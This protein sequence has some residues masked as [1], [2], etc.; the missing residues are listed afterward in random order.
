MAAVCCLPHCTAAIGDRTAMIVLLVLLTARLQ[1]GRS[2]AELTGY[3]YT[4]VRTL[5]THAPRHPPLRD[6]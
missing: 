6:A 2:C 1:L 4:T 5:L 3:I